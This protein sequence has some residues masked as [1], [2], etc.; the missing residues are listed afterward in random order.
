MGECHTRAQANARVPWHQSVRQRCISARD[1]T[2]VDDP[3][4]WCNRWRLMQ[5]WRAARLQIRAW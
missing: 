1:A 5:A 4:L 2:P 3:C